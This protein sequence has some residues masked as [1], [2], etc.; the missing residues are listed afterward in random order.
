MPAA[1]SAGDVAMPVVAWKVRWTATPNEASD[2]NPWMV[3]TPAE[4]RANP[5]RDEFE[6]V[7]KSDALVALAGRDTVIAS[8]QKFNRDEHAAWDVQLSVI[9]GELAKLTAE[10][11][12]WKA[13]CI[14]RVDD[15]KL[16]A[17]RHVATIDQLQ[18]VT[19]ERDTA[20]SLVDGYINDLRK[21]TAERDA[22]AAQVAQLRKGL[23]SA[24]T[25]IAS[26]TNDV[27]MMRETMASAAEEISEHWDAHCDGSGYGPVSLQHRLEGQ[28]GVNYPGYT[29]GAFRKLT[30]ERDTL[31]AAAR[32]AP[33]APEGQPAA[34]SRA[35]ADMFWDNDNT[36][37]CH[38]SIGD[39][40]DNEWGTGS[41]EV[42]AEFEIQRAIKLPNITIRITAIDGD[43]DEVMYEEIK[44]TENGKS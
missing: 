18:Q 15:I 19:A 9:S 37:Q 6:L 36:E 30:T 24:M 43:D 5:A 7:R 22:L 39:L 10:R 40:L 29:M 28:Y 27:T 8:L 14:R 25:E 2:A 41:I 1:E 44:Q 38:K 17:E 20:R 35:P 26:F 16:Q 23:E 4:F 3:L 42:G 11:D 13:R 21:M 32:Q 12:S 34:A 33:D 31:A